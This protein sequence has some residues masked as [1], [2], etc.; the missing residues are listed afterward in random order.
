M[1]KKDHFKQKLLPWP[2][3][4]F[5][6]EREMPLECIFAKRKSWF[7]RSNALDKSVSRAKNAWWYSTA[8]FHLSRISKQH[9]ALGECENADWSVTI[10]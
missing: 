4:P 7:K 6:E 9:C 2:Q 1:T 10:F 8:F 3:V 5:N